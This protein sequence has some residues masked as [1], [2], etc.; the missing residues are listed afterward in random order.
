MRAGVDDT[1]MMCICQANLDALNGRAQAT[2]E[3]H[4]TEV[5]RRV[6]DCTVFGKN[7]SLPARGPMPLEDNVGMGLAVEMEYR[8]LVARGQIN[9]EGFIQY[10]S[11]RKMHGTST[12]LFQS[13]PEGIASESSIGSGLEKTSLTKCPTQS[14]WYHMFNLGIAN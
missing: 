9:K 5:K 2:M 11:L 1:Y 12:K 4:A 3:T 10:Q 7:P 6:K 8:S 13:S 14:D